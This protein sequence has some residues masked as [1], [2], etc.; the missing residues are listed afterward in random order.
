MSSEIG[1]CLWWARLAAMILLWKMTCS[2]SFG[3][4]DLGWWVVM[5]RVIDRL[6][7]AV[8]WDCL[9][10]KRTMAVEKESSVFCA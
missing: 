8:S 2:G 1:G 6:L 9:W 4:P 7:L 5:V 10:M 3:A